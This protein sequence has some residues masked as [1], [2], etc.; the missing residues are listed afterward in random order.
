MPAYSQWVSFLTLRYE[1]VEASQHK[2]KAVREIAP[3][4]LSMA[5]GSAGE[6]LLQLRM[7]CSN[8]M[9]IHH[10]SVPAAADISKFENVLPT[11]F[12]GSPEY[13]WHEQL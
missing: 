2:P 9:A 1:L 6:M 11:N 8:R 4:D 13:V 5:W 3:S 7:P 10:P 12:T